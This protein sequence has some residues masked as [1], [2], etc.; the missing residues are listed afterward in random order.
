MENKNNSTSFQV[1]AI[2]LTAV[3]I[4]AT[5]Y[6]A[7]R[8]HRP[9]Q[10]TENYPSLVATKAAPNSTPAQPKSLAV[11]IAKVKI[12]GEP[13]I[14]N[15][16]APVTVAFWFDYQCPFCK[17]FEENTMSSIVS[18]YVKSGEV[19]VVF[20]DFAFL[21][22]DSQAAA[23]VSKAVW[24]AAPSKF[25]LWHQAM[26]NKQDRENSGW[27]SQADILALTKTIPGI[28]INKVEQLLA[29]KSSQYR[30]EIAADKAEGSAFGINGTPSLIIGRQLVI[31]AQPYS[32]IKQLIDLQL[33][34]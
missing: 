25:Y 23:L 28:N 6:F 15:P 22:P 5:V 2:L 1:I 16:Q 7:S 31:G 32:A 13:F 26:Y 20:K 30:Q 11:N 3:I 19:K 12:T 24:E 17:R 14:G 29:T 34:K 21:G 9:Q 8:R 18:N 27:G 10:T 33:K 4:I